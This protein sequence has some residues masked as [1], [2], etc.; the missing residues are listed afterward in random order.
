MLQISQI[1]T[2]PLSRVNTNIKM[3]QPE[4]SLH[5]G[6]LSNA[7]IQILLVFDIW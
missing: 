6:N 7:L 1:V 2:P 4:V 5:G 3:G